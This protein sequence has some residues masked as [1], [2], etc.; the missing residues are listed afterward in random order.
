M[1][2][3]QTATKNNEL[4]CA[5]KRRCAS[6]IQVPGSLAHPR[7]VGFRRGHGSMQFIPGRRALFL[8]TS[9]PSPTIHMIHGSEKL[10][11][12]LPV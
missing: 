9:F 2:Q 7:E 10:L 5:G 4:E 6:K 1:R 8:V 3:A 12:F 11:V